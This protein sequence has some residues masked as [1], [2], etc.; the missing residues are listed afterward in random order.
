[1]SVREIKVDEEKVKRIQEWP[2]PTNIGEV[3]TFHGLAT[4]YRC[5]VKDFNI[6]VVSLTDCLKQRQ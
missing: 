3:R 4:F 1:M 5:F 6:I 2:T